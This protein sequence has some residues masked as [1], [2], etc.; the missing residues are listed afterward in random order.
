MITLVIFLIMALFM[1]AMIQEVVTSWSVGERRRV[2]YEKAGGVMNVISNDL[3]LALTHEA[4]G[5]TEVKV[6]FI[7]DYDPQTGYPR[8][9]FV[10]AFEYG[11]ERAI[12]LFAGDG[13]AND[14][15]FT[16]APDPEDP[17]KPIP[18]KS[19]NPGR[20]DTD[21]FDGRRI[22]D[23]KALGGMAAVGYFVE[24]ET[25]YRAIHS[26]V[27]QS[28]AAMLSPARAQAVATDVLYFN[29]DYWS[30]E[31]T[32]WD[33][34]KKNQSGGPEK[35][36]DSTRGIDAFPLNRFFLHR[37][38]SFTLN[39]PED[40]VFPEKVRFT[41]TVDSPMPR[42]TWTRLSDEINES[43]TTI[44]VEDTRGFPDGG[45]DAFIKID[46]EWM[47]VKKKTQDTLVIAKRG[48]RGTKAAG[49]NA[50]AV[51]RVG[52]TFQ[53]VVYIP[54]F[55][56]DDTPDDVYYARK[57]GPPRAKRLNQ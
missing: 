46:D 39:D 47:L 42:C 49:H 31:T 6:R 56:S 33:E 28:L 25:L 15:M 9:M 53:R 27:P 24:K 48:V 18:K 41:V 29:I 11:P 45:D 44:Y 14:L 37:D 50:N 52:R 54:N 3:R 20:G 2:L 21:A 7:G 5:T 22:G 57:G 17:D 43:A 35:I 8:M 51:A 23:F 13:A 1:F 19:K 26:P 40:D 30:Q 34:P 36:W 16:A 55:R 12:T 32:S 10:R 4:P 38:S